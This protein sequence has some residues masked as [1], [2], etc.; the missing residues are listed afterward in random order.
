MVR[1][2]EKETNKVTLLSYTNLKFLLTVE[3]WTQL[4]KY[5]IS[6]RLR[7]LARVEIFK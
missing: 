6:S 3:L 4:T 2:K 1:G 5:F 7:T